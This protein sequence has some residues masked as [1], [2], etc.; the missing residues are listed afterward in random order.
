MGIRQT[1]RKPTNGEALHSYFE[2]IS[3]TFVF[4]TGD[5]QIFYTG[6]HLVF[7][8]GDHQIFYTGDHLVDYF[9]RRPRMNTARELDQWVRKISFSENSRQA[10]C[11]V[12]NF[13]SMGEEYF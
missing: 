2:Y 4:F 12:R 8:T 6:D 5:H 10:F 9:S 13:L 7:Y 11:Y 1:S 3:Y